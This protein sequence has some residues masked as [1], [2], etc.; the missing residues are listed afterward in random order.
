M[1]E[2]TNEDRSHWGK[3]LRLCVTGTFHQMQELL[4][5]TLLTVQIGCKHKGRVVGHK[6]KHMGQLLSKTNMRSKQ[7]LGRWRL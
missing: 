2:R 5:T 7:Q 1:P 4:K 3:Q 6:N